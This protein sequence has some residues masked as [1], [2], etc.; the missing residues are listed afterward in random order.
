MVCVEVKDKSSRTLSTGKGKR[1]R[2]NEELRERHQVKCDSFNLI[3][4]LVH[5]ESTEMETD[6]KYPFH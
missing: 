3:G 5:G 2:M 1:S 4:V 6:V